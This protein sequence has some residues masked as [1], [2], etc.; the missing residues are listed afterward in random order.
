MN[1]LVY[2]IFGLGT[3]DSDIFMFDIR[4]VA[5]VEENLKR[6][7]KSIYVSNLK[8]QEKNW[9]KSTVVVS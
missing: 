3:D 2:G 4:C 1:V 8:V 7:G 5:I 9:S 6:K